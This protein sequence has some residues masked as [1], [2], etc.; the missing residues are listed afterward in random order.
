[1]NDLQYA[2]EQT[3]YAYVLAIAGTVR[4]VRLLLGVWR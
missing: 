1:M 4:G 2:V 3:L